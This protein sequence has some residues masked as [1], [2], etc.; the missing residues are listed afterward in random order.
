MVVPFLVRPK[1][2]RV[3]ET[4]PHSSDLA[5]A[6]FREFL[7]ARLHTNDQLLRVAVPPDLSQPR[8]LTGIEIASRGR[9]LV[10]Q[11]VQ[12]SP[13]SLV[14][15]LLPHATELFLLEMGLVLEGYRPAVLP[16]P[17][18][19][20]D[21]EKYQRNLLHQLAGLP[22]SCLIT[23]PRLAENLRDGLP[24]PV[25]S[26]QIE[27]ASRYDRIFSSALSLPERVEAESPVSHGLPE[28]A[29]FVQFSG[30]TTGMQK[31]VVVT[32]PMLM[33]QLSLLQQ[34][35]DFGEG[36][37]VISWLPMYHDM[38]LIACLWFPLWSGRPSLQ[39]AN[40]DWLLNPELLFSYLERYHG[41]F[42]WLP[43]FAF[44]YLAQRQESMTRRYSLGHVRGFINCSEPVRRNS[45]KAFLERFSSWGVRPE[46]VQSSY[47]MAENVFAVTQSRL[48]REPSRVPR[49]IV[50]NGTVTRTDL[51]FSLL[52]D[53]F[54]SSGRALPGNEIRITNAQ[55]PVQADG[56]AGEIQIRT[57]SLFSG[58]WSAAGFNANSIGEDGFYKTGDYGFV[59]DGEL[60]V[61]GRLKDIMI[62]GGQNIFP[63]DVEGLVNSVPGIYPGRVVSFGTLDREYGTEAITI[64]AEMK[65]VHDPQSAQSLEKQIRSLV[66][67][68][69]GIAPRYVAVVPERWI[70][71]STAGKISRRETRERFMQEI[72][73]K[74]MG[75]GGRSNDGSSSDQGGGAGGDDGDRRPQGER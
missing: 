49:D 3:D 1:K 66:L 67:A 58:Y 59:L 54:V 6:E 71:K 55:G 61:I 43:N 4:V 53:V 19:R 70:I 37:S 62:V 73:L 29:L 36:D 72:H 31:A 69:I 52:D 41:T 38:G 42:C 65:G 11:F 68:T 47:A 5:V 40:S 8:E 35:L 33:K 17:T 56:A 63:E 30:G 34:V 32:A 10:N 22:A 26:C 14:L 23:I 50:R 57:P 9:H 27:N 64:V 45:T 39:F 15:V 2:T 20:V 60:Y 18:S 46:A 12:A 51:A 28:D 16:W 25:V 21:A 75:E 13:G 24:Y 44:S 48:D 7:E 74:A